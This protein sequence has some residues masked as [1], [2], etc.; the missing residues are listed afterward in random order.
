[1]AARTV[2]RS[3]STSSA[4]NYQA[5]AQ[6]IHDWFVTAGWIQTT[7]TGQVSIP[8]LPASSASNQNNGYEVW[9]MND[10]LQAT[11]PVFLRI[12]YGQTSGSYPQIWV[13]VG[14]GSDGA[15]N[16]TGL[17]TDQ[18][19]MTTAVNDG[20]GRN[21]YQSGG[22]NRIAM[23]MY[24]ITTTKNTGNLIFAVERTKDTSG[25]D[26]NEGV[27]LFC[28]TGNGAGRDHVAFALLFVV[29]SV[30]TGSGRQGYPPM[31]G[32]QGTTNDGGNV[33]VF[34]W[35]FPSRRGLE[36]AG[37]NVVSTWLADFPAD[38][39]FDVQIYGNATHFISLAGAATAQGASDAGT[40]DLAIETRAMLA[41]R[42]D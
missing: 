1:M 39:Q 32:A 28:S 35:L 15:G 40:Y 30:Q 36:N 34:P 38:T 16:L 26:T 19:L 3:S 18:R 21:C 23:C 24:R 9:R 2:V 10:A 27:L 13:Q 22:T 5:F 33:G 29:G 25:N 20:A 37:R 17:K 12:D 31:N 11:A 4:A 14:Q 42:Y 41:L 7:D 8:G 6:A